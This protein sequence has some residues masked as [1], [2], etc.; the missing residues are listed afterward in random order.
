MASCA[1]IEFF[2]CSRCLDQGFLKKSGV[3]YCGPCSRDSGKDVKILRSSIGI[4]HL[5]EFLA[6]ARKA[7]ELVD[8]V[9]PPMFGERERE[10]VEE[11]ARLA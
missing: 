4:G 3:K 2:L 9:P 5:R 11:L 7:Q 1:E 6:L 8:E 10:I